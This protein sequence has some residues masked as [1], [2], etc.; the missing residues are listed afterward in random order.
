MV[1]LGITRRT[2]GT[3]TLTRP[4]VH[5]ALF[6]HLPALCE[7]TERSSWHAEK[8]DSTEQRDS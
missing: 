5:P 3:D 8:D 7:P 1:S 6:P 2:E 4:R